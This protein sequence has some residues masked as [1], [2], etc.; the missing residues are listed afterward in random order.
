MLANLKSLNNKE[1]VMKSQSLECFEDLKN[2]SYVD[3]VGRVDYRDLPELMYF[4]AII[5][6]KD[7]Y[8]HELFIGC[9][10]VDKKG[11]AYRDLQLNQSATVTILNLI[12]ISKIIR[13][14]MESETPVAYRKSSLDFGFDVNSSGLDSFYFNFIPRCSDGQAKEGS[15]SMP[16][17]K[18]TLV[19]MNK[20]FLSYL[21][22]EFRRIMQQLNY[23]MK[24]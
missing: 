10:G 3:W 7:Q 6:A 23:K 2:A 20:V 4:L 22:E 21:N 5:P 16:I 19:K 1:K 17:N 11:E 14:R 24:N 18:K 13:T 8:S 12:E 15:S 9:Y